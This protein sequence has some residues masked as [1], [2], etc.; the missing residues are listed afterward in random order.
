MALSVNVD[1]CR[2]YRR[3]KKNRDIFR[4]MTELVVRVRARVWKA[5]TPD[6]LWQAKRTRFAFAFGS[7]IA[8][9]D[10]IAFDL[11]VSAASS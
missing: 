1:M 4:A 2:R 9:N 6:G 11:P 7:S 3:V 10:I 5:D 8:R